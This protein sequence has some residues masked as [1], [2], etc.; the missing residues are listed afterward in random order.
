MALVT[1]LLAG[2]GVSTYSAVE[3][4]HRAKIAMLGEGDVERASI[5]ASRAEARS[6]RLSANLVLDRALKPGAEGEVA[7]SLQCML[8]SLRTSS[9]PE[10]HRLIR[11]D[12]SSWGGRVPTLTHWLEARHRMSAFAPA[13]TS[14]VGSRPIRTNGGPLPVAA[15]FTPTQRD[16]TSLAPITSAP[17]DSS[18]PR[19]SRPGPANK[20]GSARINKRWAAARW[21]VDQLLL[22]K[23]DD[24]DL[25]RQRSELQNR[26]A[27]SR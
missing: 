3:F 9:D 7:E 27:S 20:P 18:L 10:L 24:E 13:G 22:L 5:A 1:T 8:A 25:L 6:A 12:M 11:T 23:P 4:S 26:D 19:S 17:P 14:I 21:Y 16:G 15:A 2:T